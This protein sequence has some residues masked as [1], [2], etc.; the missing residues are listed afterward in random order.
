MSVRELPTIFYTRTQEYLRGNA[1]GTI[2]KVS[3]ESLTPEDEAFDREDQDPEW[4][5]IVRFVW[6]ICGTAYTGPPATPPSRNIGAL[7][8]TGGLV[9]GHEPRGRGGG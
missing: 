3:Y 5:Y 2:V 9:A 8:P 7:A 1:S 4:F 6:Q